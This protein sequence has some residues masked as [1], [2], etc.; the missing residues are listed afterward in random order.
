MSQEAL[1]FAN[2]GLPSSAIR[3]RQYRMDDV[4]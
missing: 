2:F 1:E 3:L 4:E